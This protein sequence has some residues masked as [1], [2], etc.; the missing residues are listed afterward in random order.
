MM[1]A[2]GFHENSMKSVLI[3]LSTEFDTGNQPY[4]FSLDLKN[5]EF[6]E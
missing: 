1:S 5:S 3:L 4:Y 2:I 6:L